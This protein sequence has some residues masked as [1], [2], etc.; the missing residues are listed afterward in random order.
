MKLTQLDLLANCNTI[1]ISKV[2]NSNVLILIIIL[3]GIF[4]VH[5]ESLNDAVVYENSMIMVKI[6]FNI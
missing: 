5:V 1:F 2:D 3:C 6:L 4:Y